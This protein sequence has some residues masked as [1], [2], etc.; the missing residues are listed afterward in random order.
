MS[1]IYYMALKDLRLLFRDRFGLFWIFVFP[2]IHA[3]FFGTIFGGSGPR[4]AIPV[5]VIDEANSAVSQEFASKLAQTEGLGVSE[6]DA[7]VALEGARELVRKGERV[8]YI[9]IPAGYGGDAFAVFQGG[10]DDLVEIGIDPS[11]QAERGMIEGLVSQVAF[12]NVFTQFSDSDV[13]STQIAAARK[14]LA[15]AEELSAA[16]QVQ[17]DI[18]MGALDTFLQSPDGGFGGSGD[19]GDSDGAG[20]SGMAPV[21]EV[22]EVS[23]D[24]SGKPKSSF[25]L[26]FPAAIVWALMGCVATFSLSMV[27]ERTM[28]TL[29]RL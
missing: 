19:S 17:L 25:E 21:V 16:K 22:V 1:A 20:N 2:L 9:R 11:R 6:E 5:V 28:G 27:R 15:T 3:L 23:R 29:L 4:G 10:S 24:R 18:F 12:Q 13:M 8:A 14:Q 26:T 7:G